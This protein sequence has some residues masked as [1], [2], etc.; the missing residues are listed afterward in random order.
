MTTADTE[1]IVATIRSVVPGPAALHEPVFA[2]NEWAYVKECLDTGWVSTAGSFVERFESELV[3]LTGARHVIATNSGTSAL[4]AALLIA[5]IRQGDEVLIPS[6]SFVA[7]ANAVSHTGATAHFV[8]VERTSFGIDPDALTAY[9]EKVC[10]HDG[11]G[12]RNIKTGRPV[13]AIVCV[14]VFGHPAQLER[15]REIA[16]THGLSLVEDAA[17]SLGTTYHDRHTG[18]FGHLGIISFNGN[19]TITTGAGGA[20]LT[21]DDDLAEKLRRVTTTAKLPHPWIYDHDAVAFN[22]R[23]PNINAALGCAQLEL[24]PQF[25]ENKRRLAG[26]YIDAFTDIAGISVLQEPPGARSNYWLNAL[27][28]ETP[29]REK[30]DALLAAANEAGIGVRPAWKPLHTLEMYATN[31]RAELKNTTALYD[32]IV[33]LPSGPGLTPAKHA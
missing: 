8:D 5:G 25:I 28:F 20:I 3:D 23:L 33:N 32:Q 9:L 21:D 2:G 29:D 22:Y 31:P 15:L 10:E 6:L 27:V 11:T 1:E 24:L 19:K 17:E 30:R 16:D 14:H 13:T 12:L 7:T 18:T 26:A 4:H